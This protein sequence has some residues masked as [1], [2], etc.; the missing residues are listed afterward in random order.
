[1]RKRLKKALC[2]AV[3][4]FLSVSMIMGVTS[5]SANA[6]VDLDCNPNDFDFIDDEG[7]LH[8]KA[9]DEL[10]N[11]FA[12]CKTNCNRYDNETFELCIGTRDFK[13]NG[14]DAYIS[15]IEGIKYLVKDGYKM[16]NTTFDITVKD[17]SGKPMY[18][19]TTYDPEKEYLS[20]IYI[21]VTLSDGSVKRYL[22]A[23]GATLDEN[24]QKSR[25]IY[26]T[27]KKG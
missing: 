27:L 16:V 3:A 13:L 18:L 10:V 8:G 9:K 24:L 15:K 4:A 17:N 2:V 6:S 1:M 12:V 21:Y 20:V 11:A 22:V 23:V 5:V 25:E 19:C 26:N 7:S 14:K